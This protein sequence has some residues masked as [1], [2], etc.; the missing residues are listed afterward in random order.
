MTKWDK[1]H[2]S[3]IEDTEENERLLNEQINDTNYEAMRQA[4]EYV[5]ELNGVFPNSGVLYCGD[6]EIEAFKRY[7]EASGV[8]KNIYWAKTYKRDVLGIEFIMK[9]DII[10]IIK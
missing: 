7:K 8:Q 9:Y 3:K 10:K 4:E 6:N 1:N 5:V 2:I